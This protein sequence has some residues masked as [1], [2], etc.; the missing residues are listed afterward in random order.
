MEK[1]QKPSF[2]QYLLDRFKRWQFYVNMLVFFAGVLMYFDENVMAVGCLMM[3]PL[4]AMAAIKVFKHKAMAIEPRDYFYSIFSIALGYLIFQLGT[5][6]W[7][8]IVVIFFSIIV[9]ILS[10]YNLEAL[11]DER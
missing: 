4:V 11:K 7:Q 3:T 9:Y 8:S 10:V 6:S 2:F 1:L 5:I